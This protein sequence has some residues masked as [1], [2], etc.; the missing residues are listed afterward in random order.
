MTLRM[1]LHLNEAEPSISLHG[2]L[3]GPEVAEFER[4]LASARM[5]MSIDLRHLMGADRR[6]LV[7]LCAQ[8]DRSVRLSNSS[9]YIELLLESQ[10]MPAPVLK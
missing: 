8:R 4:V 5:P 3:A 10:D 6:G 9:P 1:V 2:W 7:A